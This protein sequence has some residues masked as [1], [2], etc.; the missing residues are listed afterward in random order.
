MRRARYFVVMAVA[1]GGCG[2]EPEP[3]PDILEAELV[4]IVQEKTGTGGLVLVDC[5][6]DVATDPEVGDI[7]KVTASG[8]VGA[9]VRITN[10]DGVDVDAEIVQ[11]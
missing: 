6:A 8:G 4:K 9:K 7:C 5:P 10:V 2:G 11:P 3:E 1:L